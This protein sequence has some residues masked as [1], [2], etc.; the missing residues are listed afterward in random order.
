MLIGVKTMINLTR[1]QELF[2]IDL[3]I[4]T[5]V[6]KHSSLS[7]AKKNVPWNKGKKFK[8]AGWTAERRKSFSAMMKKRWAK[9][10]N[11]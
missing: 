1:T 8:N 7:P 10:Q 5:L 11:K 6:D 2:L 3:G 9:K 4:R